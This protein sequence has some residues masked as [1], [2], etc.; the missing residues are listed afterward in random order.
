MDNYKCEILEYSKWLIVVIIIYS[1]DSIK[2]DY[3]VVKYKF[4]IFKIFNK[5]KVWVV[6]YYGK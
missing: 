2:I 3:L 1:N 5:V 4:K 6:F